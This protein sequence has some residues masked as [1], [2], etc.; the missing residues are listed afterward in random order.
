M[1][2]A[3]LNPHAGESGAFGDE[4]KTIIEPV[5]ERLRAE[6]FRVSGPL[7]ADTMFAKTPGRT[8]TSLFACIMIR[9]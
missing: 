4:E 5:L 3:G 2:V 6:G 8:T 9:R 7:P 1:A